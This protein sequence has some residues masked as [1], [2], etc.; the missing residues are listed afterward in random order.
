MGGNETLLL[1]VA[2]LFGEKFIAKETF[3]QK[4]NFSHPLVLIVLVGV[5]ATGNALKCHQCES[6]T[7]GLCADPFN[8][9]V[10]N[11]WK[12]NVFLKDCPNDGN[13]YKFCRKIYQNVRGDERIIRSCGYEVYKNLAGEEKKEY[14]TVLEEYN[15]FVT[16]CDFDG[17]NSSTL[18]QV[19]MVSVLMAMVLAVVFK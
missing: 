9:T 12:T 19:S 3:V 6:Y 13:T 10:T 17:C 7:E 2:I 18:N 15:T 16:T 11:M 14:T 4:M 5:F 8:D 1:Q